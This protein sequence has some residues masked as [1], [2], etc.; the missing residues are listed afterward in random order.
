M[1]LYSTVR[2]WR[3]LRTAALS[4]LSSILFPIFFFSSMGWYSEAGVFGRIKYPTC[5]NNN[6]NNN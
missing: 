1:A 4:F 6:N 5:F 2:D 3:L